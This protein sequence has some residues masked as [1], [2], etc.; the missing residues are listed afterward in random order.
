MPGKRH[1][2]TAIKLVLQELDSGV[3]VRELISRHGISEQTLYRWKAKNRSKAKA[4]EPAEGDVQDNSP[5]HSVAE[6]IRRLE[7]ENALLRQIAGQ[8]A[9]EKLILEAKLST[10]A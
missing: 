6:R 5:R 7:D 9:L 2:Q 1:S 3:P 4:P 10:A 8:L